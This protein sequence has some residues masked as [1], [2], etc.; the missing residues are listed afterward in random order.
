MKLAELK[1][2]CDPEWQRIA[3]HPFVEGIGRGTLTGAQLQYFITQDALYLRDFYRVLAM[4]GG[5][6]DGS[7]AARTMIH[8]AE[9]VFVV[10]TSLHETIAETFG[11]RREDIVRTP[12]GLVTKLYGDH[13]VRTAYTESVPV[14][15]AALLP[16][17]WTYQAIGQ[18]WATNP[19]QHPLLRQWID[20][21]QGDAYATAVAEVVAIAENIS[22]DY[23]NL[24]AI[25]EAFHHSM[26]CERLFWEQAWTEGKVLGSGP[27]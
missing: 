10:E 26:V 8:H 9:T 15:L 2:N 13:L 14:L 23:P 22:E 24:D 7:Q 12:K 27:E 4:A 6:L 5:R 19:P 11:L 21:Y 20:T 1:E 18:Q 17:Y 16:C 25:T 3:S